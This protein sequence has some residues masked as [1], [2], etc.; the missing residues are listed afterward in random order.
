ML[1]E[2]QGALLAPV[3][4][5]LA[6]AERDGEDEQVVTVDEAGLGEA[7][8]ERRA[9]VHDDVPA[10]ALL[11][12]GDLVERAQHRCVVPLGV[13]QGRRDDVLGHRVVLVELVHLRPD[14]RELVVA[15]AAEQHRA[16]LELLAAFDLV[17]LL[18]E[19]DLLEGPAGARVVAAAGR[20]DDAVEGDELGDD[21]G[22]H[23]G[24]LCGSMGRTIR[25]HSGRRTGSRAIDTA[26][27]FP[28][29][30]APCSAQ[31]SS[32]PSAATC[33]CRLRVTR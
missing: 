1:D 18:D 26:P 2:L 33:S 24:L 32:T 22:A 20:V 13:G 11:E 8:R 23:G 12:L 4:E 28:G 5:A 27:E 31:A 14:G 29:S 15:D 6:L 9:A 3:E 16:G 17:R 10:V 19:R 30:V 7:L 21:E 25:P